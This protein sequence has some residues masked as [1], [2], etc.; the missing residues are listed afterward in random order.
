MRPSDITDRTKLTSDFLR[1]YD[2]NQALL[3][4]YDH[5]GVWHET[6]VA[7][8]NLDEEQLMEGYWFGR[9]HFL[10]AFRGDDHSEMRYLFCSDDDDTSGFTKDRGFMIRNSRF[11]KTLHTR[12]YYEADNDGQYTVVYARPLRIDK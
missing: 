1:E 11:G 4:F 9:D 10:H 8:S 5:I 2:L 3:Y 6:P 7:P 12:Y